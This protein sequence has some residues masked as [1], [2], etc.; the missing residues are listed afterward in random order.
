M[1]NKKQKTEMHGYRSL[2]EQGLS[3]KISETQMQLKRTRFSHA[4]NP[5]ENPLTIR[6]MRREI[7][8]MKTEENKRAQAQG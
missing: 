8:R 4:V 7:A 5:V 2:D 1:A 6:A 3:D